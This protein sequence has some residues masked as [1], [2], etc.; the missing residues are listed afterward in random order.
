M[1]WKELKR[2]MGFA[3]S[4]LTRR[5]YNLLLQVTNRCNM[6]C[7]FCDFPRNAVTPDEEL[8]LEDLR[9]LSDQLS[10]MGRFVVS[11]EG[12][13]P[14]VRP[15]LVE[16]VRLFSRDHI[17]VLYTNGWYV[18]SENA[19]ELFD[20]GL[21]QAGVS[22]DYPDRRHDAKR[23]LP[24][25]FDRACHAVDLFRDAAPHGGKQVHIMT[26]L[27]RDN[28]QDLEDLLKLSAAHGVGH[29]VTLL[30]DR[31]FRRGKGVDELPAFPISESLL[32]LWKRHPHWRF[33]REY[34]E[35]MDDFLS[36]G[37]MPPCRA[38]LQTFNIDHV[39]NVAVCIEK[40]HRP[41]GNIRR[42]LLAEIHARI[43]ADRKD[44][45]N[46]QDCWTACRAF[47]QLMS[48]GGSLRNWWGM[49]RRM[50]SQ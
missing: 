19:R 43:T 20:A 48:D 44:A 29:I 37:S 8:S 1:S 31:G 11:I 50:R 24:G 22:V 13:E 10:G 41:S 32:D 28:A 42:E 38:G 23:G 36:G 2:E 16:I 45:E 39:G 21:A 25:S 9:C 40:I 5:P 35:R 18:T 6:K 49:A 15:D 47:G 3:C 4:V 30:S 17:A 7:T 12:G 46:C 14:F 34:L 27:M 26:V 33:W